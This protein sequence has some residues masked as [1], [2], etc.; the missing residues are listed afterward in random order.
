MGQRSIGAGDPARDYIE[1]VVVD[2]TTGEEKEAGIGG[3]GDAT[4]DNQEA[5]LDRFGEK[6]ET[7]SVNTLLWRM[8]ELL[9][10]W[11]E[12]QAD[13]SSSPVHASGRGYQ[14][15]AVS[16]S[17][18]GL[19]SGAAGDELD[20]FWIFPADASLASAVIIKDG[21]TTVFTYPSGATPTGTPHPIPVVLNIAAQDAAGFSVTTP[22]DATV[23]AIGRFTA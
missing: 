23:L 18:T 14:T 2:K 7:P 9:D 11:V 20:M 16:A 17:E 10:L 8:K 19:G 6:S 15:V 1:V 3:G 5:L 13:G 12:I 4:S 22:S 21:S